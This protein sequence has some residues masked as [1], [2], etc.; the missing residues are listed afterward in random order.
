MS[1]IIY[2]DSKEQIDKDII[3]ALKKLKHKVI[4]VE[5]LDFKETAD[6]FLFRNTIIPTDSFPDFFNKLIELQKVLTG[7]KYKKALWFTDKVMGLGQDLLETIIPLVDATF[8][9]D[10]TWIRRHDYKIYPL[11]LAAGDMEEG[12]YE[13]KYDVDI[14]YNGIVY[15]PMANWVGN[16]KHIFGSRFKLFNVSGKDFADLC[17]S[18]KIMIIP[19]FLF[20][21]FYWDDKIYKTLALG[22]FVIHPRLYGMDLK[23]GEHYISYD[24]LTELVDATNWFLKYP[25]ERDSIVSKGMAEVK[26]NFTYKN[27]LKELLSKI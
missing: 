12:K 27:R 5:D 17:A 19:R 4:L 23:D 21:D 11:H 18:A 15:P 6:L 22:G 25:P 3:K 16:M 24:S 8:L 14:A 7:L 1:K 13:K 26:K 2:F 9:N 20:D 10:D